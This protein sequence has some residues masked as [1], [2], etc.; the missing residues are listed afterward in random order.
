MEFAGE[1]FAD[2]HDA[3]G[4]N[5]GQATLDDWLR[6]SA[7]DSDG[8]NLTRTYVSHRGDGIVV[9]FYA[10]MPYFIERN[11]LDTKQRRGLPSRIPC[12]LQGRLALAEPLHDRG[13]GS[14]VLA[15]A[16][17]RVATGSRELGGRYVVVDAI[18]DA[19]DAFYRHHGFEPVPGH[20]RGLILATKV[21]RPYLES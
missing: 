5:S 17:T 16:L 9:A 10:L 14:Q 20:E 7:R 21:L 19:A 15:S 8:R 2:G 4:F 12:Y 6:H 11:T 13:L 3:A 1:G 18:D